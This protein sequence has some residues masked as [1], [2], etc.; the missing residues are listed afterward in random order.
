MK[1][2]FFMFIL[3]RKI[4]LQLNHIHLWLLLLELPSLE[5]AAEVGSRNKVTQLWEACLMRGKLKPHS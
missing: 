2:E 4:T 3:T 1:Q 5:T